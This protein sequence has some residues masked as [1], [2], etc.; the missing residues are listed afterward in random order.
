M[1]IL[2]RLARQPHYRGGYRATHGFMGRTAIV[3]PQELRRP[4]HP[5]IGRCWVM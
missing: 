5:C 1:Q 3:T 4:V 2:E